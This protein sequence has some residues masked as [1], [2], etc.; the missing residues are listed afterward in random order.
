MH[1]VWRFGQFL[2]IVLLGILPIGAF[3]ASNE[4]LIRQL[5]EENKVVEIEVKG[6]NWEALKN[7]DPRGGI[8]NF[9][10]QE[11]RYD[12]FAFDSLTVNG[13]TFKNVGLRKKSWC[14]SESK[15]KPAFNVKIDKFEK[16]NGFLAETSLGT[17]D[18]MLN[19]SKQDESIVRQCFTYKFFAR[20]GV[21]APLCNFAHVTVN[22]QDMGLYVNVQPIKKSFLKMNFGNSSGNLYEIAA[23]N[24][25][26]NYL[27]WY[28]A[29][30]DS[31]KD[32]EDDSLSDVKTM[33]E[34]LANPKAGRS[35]IGEKVD[36]DAFIRFWAGEILL[37]HHDGFT[38]GN[39]NTYLY[40]PAEGKMQVLPY[41]VDQTLSITSAA[42]VLQIY[43]SN[44][45]ARRLGSEIETL[46]MLKALLR[47]TLTESWNEDVL[48]QD[49]E[50]SAS[51]LRPYLRSDG[52]GSFEQ[53]LAALKAN[54]GKRRAEIQII[55]EGR[56]N[57]HIQNKSQPD[58]CLNSQIIDGQPLSNVFT[59]NDH[60]DQKWEILK[61]R[62]GYSQ[63][64]NIAHNNCVNLQG[65]S[66]ETQVGSWSCNPHPDQ[67][68]KAVLKEGYYS[69]E[70]QRAPGK[71]LAMTSAGDTSPVVIRNCSSRDER[72]KWLSR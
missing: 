20:L 49:V 53:S 18:L 4:A 64:R 29:G 38:L 27:S 50:R 14:G 54:I 45:L 70:S 11:T 61:L 56:Y 7:Q 24:F 35:A 5:Y 57:V 63:I 36:V 6:S 37:S 52:K 28:A 59:C 48:V 17:A 19:N 65:D 2:S 44:L 10:Y 41:G 12:W 42:G 71:C 30:L 39:N 60:Q 3:A 22:G 8:C 72:Q 16:K 51:V 67:S 23:Y 13:E 15:I 55:M 1:R 32:P 62:N 58:F 40:F 68:W 47:D 34:L 26:I 31:Y 69:F 43:Q 66:E 21:P 46:N 9:N 33:I 25:D